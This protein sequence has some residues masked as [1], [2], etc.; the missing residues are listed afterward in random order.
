MTPRQGKYF[1]LPFLQATPL[2]PSRTFEVLFGLTRRPSR[3]RDLPCA[4]LLE[5]QRNKDTLVLVAEIPDL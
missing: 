1:F 3:A 2:S 4:L 5:L